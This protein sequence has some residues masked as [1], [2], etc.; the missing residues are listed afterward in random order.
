VDP[1]V[2]RLVALCDAEHDQEADHREHPVDEER[3]A[4]PSTP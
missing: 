3:T 4:D 2:R 1:V